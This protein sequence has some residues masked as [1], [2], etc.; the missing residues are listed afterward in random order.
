MQAAPLPEG[1]EGLAFGRCCAPRGHVG[2]HVPR[3][4]S[5]A[6]RGEGEEERTESDLRRTERRS[7]RGGGGG[8]EVEEEGRCGTDAGSLRE[9]VCV[10][11]GGCVA[12]DV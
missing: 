8:E 1:G 12:V 11:K 2:G 10:C 4:S 9:Y 5:S 3:L 6:C 7:D